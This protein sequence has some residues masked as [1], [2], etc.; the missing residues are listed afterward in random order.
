MDRHEALAWSS[1]CKTL[2]KCSRPNPGHALFWHSSWIPAL[3]RGWRWEQQLDPGS[4]ERMEPW[5]SLGCHLQQ[6]GTQKPSTARTASSICTKLWGAEPESC[7][8]QE[9]PALRRRRALPVQHICLCRRCCSPALPG[10]SAFKLFPQGPTENNKRIVSFPDGIYFNLYI[11]C[12][13]WLILFLFYF[14][15]NSIFCIRYHYCE[16][17]MLI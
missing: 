1:K 15:L 12:N 5:Q 17:I 16:E 14:F 8:W 11:T 2:F 13:F 7:P 9:T 10:H 3:G 6:P 4:V